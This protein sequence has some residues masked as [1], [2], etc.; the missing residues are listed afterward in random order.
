VNVCS[1]PLQ[2]NGQF[3]ID[4]ISVTAVPEPAIS[5]MLS[6]GLLG[7]ALRSRRSAR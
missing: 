7:L 3:A 6:L 1:G 4:N 5:V 2:N